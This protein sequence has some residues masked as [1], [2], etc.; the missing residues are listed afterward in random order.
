[1]RTARI[2][3][4]FAYVMVFAASCVC[5]QAQTQRLRGTI[6]RVDGNTLIAKGRDGASITLTLADN[7][8]DYRRLQGDACRYQGR[9]LHRQ[10]RDAAS[11]R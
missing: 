9:R 11:R 3:A 8:T 5:A 1:M 4:A 10:R 7:A 2:L 6:E